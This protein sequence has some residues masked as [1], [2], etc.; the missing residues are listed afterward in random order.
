ME[1]TQTLPLHKKIEV[2]GKTIIVPTIIKSNPKTSQ[3]LKDFRK[4]VKQRQNEKKQCRKSF[5]YYSQKRHF[6]RWTGSP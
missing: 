6:C 4:G 5:C 3:I 1:S 2:L